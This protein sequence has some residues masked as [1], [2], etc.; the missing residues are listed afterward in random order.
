L[1][2]VCGWMAVALCLASCGTGDDEH[3]PGIMNAFALVT[4]TD[5]STGEKICGAHVALAAGAETFV[6]DESPPCSYTFHDGLLDRELDLAVTADGYEPS[7]T[8]V[9]IGTDSCDL[10]ETEDVLVELRASGPP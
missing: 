3:C 4:V 9:T 1:S 5:A 6:A 10:P 8:T 2:P 7:S